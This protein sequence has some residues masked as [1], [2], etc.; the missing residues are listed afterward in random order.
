MSEFDENEDVVSGVEV[1]HRVNRL[2]IKAGAA[3][4]EDGPGFID[5][6]AINRAQTII[7]KR[8]AL[9]MS[10][11]EKVLVKLVTVWDDLKKTG[12]GEKSG[13]L[14]KKLSLCA[15]NIK[16]LASTFDYELMQHFGFS[17]RS[18]TEKIDMKNKAHHIIVQ[19]HID[20]MWVVYKEN[21]KDEGGPKAAELKK[22]VAVAIEKYS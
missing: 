7:E 15:N 20:V 5:P 17:L 1:Y 11:V 9:Y 3:S 10:E 12:A 19:A 13:T 22:I 16:D 4:V 18:F 14:I 21:I 6:R 2:K 8:Q